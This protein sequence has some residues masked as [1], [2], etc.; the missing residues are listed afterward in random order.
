[1]GKV[2]GG[3]ILEKWRKDPG[4]LSFEK[5]EI[6]FSSVFTRPFLMH[7]GRNIQKT[8]AIGQILKVTLR[9]ESQL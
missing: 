9:G 7:L 1:M 2:V 8:G 4:I 6:F 5:L 3:S